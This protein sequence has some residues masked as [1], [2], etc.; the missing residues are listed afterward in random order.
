MEFFEGKTLAEELTD[1]GV[2]K[3]QKQLKK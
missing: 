1:E 2:S 3:I